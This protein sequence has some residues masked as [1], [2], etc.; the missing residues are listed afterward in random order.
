M[1]KTEWG[2]ILAYLEKTRFSLF[3]YNYPVL[4]KYH[5]FLQINIADINDIAPMKIAAI[6]DRG[7]K[8]DF[9]DLYFILKI[10][11]FFTIKE[12]LELYNKKF[13]VLKSNRLYILKSLCYF[14]DAD[15]DEMPKMIEKV[16]WQK[17]KEFFIEEVRK[18]QKQCLK[19][20]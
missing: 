13:K 19:Q 6:A 15:N 16:K 8:R 18:Y 12:G 3:F 2:T 5:K 14:K 20:K 17:I 9:I 10:K 7:T 4:A 11:K 1:E